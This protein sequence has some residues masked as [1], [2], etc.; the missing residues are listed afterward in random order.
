M[1]PA[2]PAFPPFLAVMLSIASTQVGSAIAKTLFTQLSPAGVTFLRVGFA[3][4]VLMVLWRP[5]FA[6]VQRSDYPALIGFGLALAFMNLS[7]YLATERIP[8]AIAV[9]LEF[10]G[11][12]G[13]AVAHSRRWM[14]ALWVVLAAAGIVLLAPI[15]PQTGFDAVGV[16]LAL[17]AGG[18]WAAYILLSAQV[19]QALPGGTG[20][21]WSMV[22][23]T[24]VLLPIGVIGGGAALLSPHLLLVSF[25]VALL[26][27]ALPY[28]L[29]LE[30]LRWMPVQ[31]FG[32]LLSLEPA[33]AAVMGFLILGETLTLQAILA[34]ILV[35]IAAAGASRFSSQEGVS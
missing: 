16:G 15:N 1:K 13:V 6:Q 32:V 27:S 2:R 5:K 10:L 25:G 26:S 12:L 24:V 30:V 9:T 35:S 14:D 18:F 21:A 23:G 20:L 7:F 19:G 17:M 28:S 11:P 33:A 8:L 29:E 4:V 34:V 31:V 22:V 3:A